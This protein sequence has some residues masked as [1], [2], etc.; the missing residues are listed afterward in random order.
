[1]SPTVRMEDHP[2]LTRCW[3]I[4][5]PSALDEKGTCME[6]GRPLVLPEAAKCAGCEAFRDLLDRAE[7]RR[8]I[9]EENHL[10]ASK[11]LSAQLDEAREGVA[12]ILRAAFHQSKPSDLLLTTPSDAVTEIMNLNDLCLHLEAE[13]DEARAEKAVL[14]ARAEKAEALIADAVTF[15]RDV[16]DK[17]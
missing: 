14:L 16:G 1:V 11:L 9:A 2:C 13:R 17:S 8:D 5:A 10:A 7:R 15:A 4:G 6:C 12:S 3:R